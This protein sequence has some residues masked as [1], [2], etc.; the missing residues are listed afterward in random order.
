MGFRACD[1]LG[2]HD[3]F[4]GLGLLRKEHLYRGPRTGQEDG[5]L[6]A[7]YCPAPTFYKPQVARCMIPS[8]TLFFPSL[9]LRVP[10]PRPWQCL[11]PLPPLVPPLG[12]IQLPP[13][14]PTSIRVIASSPVTLKEL[15][16]SC[17]SQPNSSPRLPPKSASLSRQ[18]NLSSSLSCAPLSTL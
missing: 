18:E 4:I 13:L 1:S 15:V 14:K 16:A 11:V 12:P 7:P 10:E 8:H 3:E 5:T 6:R 9:R 2:T 17:P